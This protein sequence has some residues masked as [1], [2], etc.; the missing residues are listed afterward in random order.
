MS[1][2]DRPMPPEPLIHEGTSYEPDPGAAAW[3]KNTFVDSG[4]ELHNEDHQHLEFA[5]LG[6]VW[7]NERNQR[8]QKRVLGMAETVD[9]RDRTWKRGRQQHQLREWFGEL[10][11]F[12][13]TLYA[14]HVAGLD[15]ASFCALV[16]HE[17]FH[18]AQELDEYGAPVFGK[19]GR[20]KWEIRAHDVEEFTGVVRRYGLEAAGPGVQEMVDAASAEPEVAAAEIDGACGTCARR[21][22]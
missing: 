15:D 12:L 19:D 10:P 2:G 17:L 6:V 20:P 4:G 1:T 18:C 13:I 22:A 16:E 3:M 14:P 7:T 11:D 9:F 8:K 5:W 21:A